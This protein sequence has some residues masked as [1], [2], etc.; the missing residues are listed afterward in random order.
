MWRCECSC[1]RATRVQTQHLVE[2]RVVSCGCRK[3]ERRGKSKFPA[4]VLANCSLLHLQPDIASQWHPVK[5]ETTPDLWTVGSDQKVW[6]ICPTCKQE[7]QALIYHR[8]KHGCPFCS[9][10]EPTALRNLALMNPELVLEW[11]EDNLKSPSQYLPHSGAKVKWVCRKCRHTWSAAIKSR[12]LSES[13]CP[14]CLGRVATEASNLA[15]RFPDLVLE[16]HHNKNYLQ[17][18]KFTPGSKFKVW[19]ICR[20]CTYEWRASIVNR[21]FNNTGC[22]ACSESGYKRNLPGYFYLQK[23]DFESGNSVLKFGITNRPPSVRKAEQQRSSKA[24]HTF[25]VDPIYYTDGQVPWLIETSI[26]QKFRQELRAAESFGEIFDGSTETLMLER[27]DAILYM[28]KA[29]A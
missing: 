16:W 10:R 24:T 1:G 11:A 2:G 15:T 18:K 25:I 7:W 6:W 17:P 27:L 9:G 13:G 8:R 4:E 23:V 12:T 28:V 22:P 19:W 26:K 29:A 14:A 3:K 21:A 20:K 5:N